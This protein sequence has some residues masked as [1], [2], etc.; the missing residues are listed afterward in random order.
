MTTVGYGDKTPKKVIA[1]IF[2][3]IWIITGIALFNIVT[4]EI[5]TILVQAN[6]PP[7]PNVRGQIVGVLKFRDYDKAY[8]TKNGGVV[9]HVQGENFFEEL[10]NLSLALR[11]KKIDGII[12]DKSTMHYSQGLLQQKAAVGN[13]SERITAADFFINKTLRFEKEFVGEKMAYGVLVKY[14]R[15]YDYFRSA[16]ADNRLSLV[17][18]K[19]ANWNTEKVEVH[20]NQDLFSPS[21]FYFVN[22]MIWIW[23]TIGVIIVFGVLFEIKRRDFRIF[24]NNEPPKY[25]MNPTV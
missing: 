24:N 21:G 10:Y 18:D 4:G 20:T 1:R 12:F 14:K 6:N 17:S 23:S 2:S 5:T 15:H 22:G 16:L 19:E 9:H 11:D 3:V 25:E 7:A 8:V 13:M